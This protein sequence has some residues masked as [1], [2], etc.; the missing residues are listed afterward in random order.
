[1]PDGWIPQ[2]LPA[3]VTEERGPAKYSARYAYRDGVM[4]VHR[5]YALRVSG[6]CEATLAGEIA[7]VIKA[8]VRDASERLAFVPS[9][10]RSASQ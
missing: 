9:T 3:D 7:P 4:E 6:V 5:S 8:A 10:R 2:K 1:L